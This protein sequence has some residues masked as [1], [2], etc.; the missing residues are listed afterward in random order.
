[1]KSMLRYTGLM[2]FGVLI[3]GVGNLQA[4]TLQDAVHYMLQTNPEIRAI[5]FNRLARNEEVK[6]AQSGYLP[7]VDVSYSTGYDELNKLGAVQDDTSHP[8]STTLSV[9]QNVFQGFATKYEVERQESRVESAAYLLQGTSENIALRTSRVFLNVLRQLE[10]LDLAKENVTIH[11]R[12]YDQIKLRSES[13]LDR[14]A[15]LDQVVARLALAE[16]DVVVTGANVADAM[17]DYQFTV[18]RMPENLI[19]PHSVDSATPASLDEVVQMAV[20]DYP[21]LKSAKSDVKAREAQ[22][23]VAKSN[24]YPKVDLV[25]DQRWEDEV[26]YNEYYEEFSAAAVVRFNIFNGWKDKARIAETR[27][28]ICEAREIR[29]NT[30]RQVVESVRLSWVAYQSTLSQIIFLEEYAKSTGVTAE[31][32]SK[33]WNIGRRTMFDVLDI[34]AE[35]IN[36]KIDLVNARYDKTYAQYRVLSGIGSLV[37]TLGLQWPVESYV[38]EE[39]AQV[40]TEE[41]PAGG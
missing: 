4:E 39:Q 40:Q 23:V 27:K 5:S 21:I 16:S 17:T 38:E 41:G 26:D 12:I 22:Y 3:W 2:F 35:L 9:R 24:Y 13:G 11:Q 1:M 36:A 8:K 30:H 14:K 15:D 6:Q 34:E 33:Q 19:K 18:G 37:H 29:N 31:A 32:F 7:I 20:A 25:A 10:I 28:L